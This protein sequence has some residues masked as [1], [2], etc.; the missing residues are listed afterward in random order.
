MYLELVCLWVIVLL[1]V[2][3]GVEAS[4]MQG[5]Q[6]PWLKSFSLPEELRSNPVWHY[7]LHIGLL[8]SG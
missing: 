6:V 4:E 7:N 3:L 1:F 2:T 5:G 8:C